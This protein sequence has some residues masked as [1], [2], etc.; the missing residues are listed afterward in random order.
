MTS[1]LQRPDRTTRSVRTKFFKLTE[2]Q[3]I[4]RLLQPMGEIKMVYTHWLNR[5]SI[6]CLGD[7]C[8]ICS[9]NQEIL[10]RV[11]KEVGQKEAWKQAKK[12]EGFNPWQ[13]RYYANVLDRTPVKV[14]PEAA[15]GT[16]NKINAAGEFP[17]LCEET[18][19]PL[20]D[21][22]VTSS[23]TVRVLSS[24]KTLF[25]DLDAIDLATCGLESDESG[26]PIPLGI[27]NYDVALIVSGEGRERNVSPVPQ[28]S[29]NDVVEVTEELYDLNK[30]IITLTSDEVSSFIRGVS[31]RDIFTSRNAIENIE[32]KKEAIA[33]DIETVSNLEDEIT[34]SVKALL[35]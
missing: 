1:R 17:V 5:I 31:L 30:A 22:P 9:N 33:Q 11:S 18:K 12:E 3:H 28:A 19:L 23:N 4:I 29:R 8:P 7:T 15:K 27:T 10:T 16:E 35:D 26:M 2:G 21:V 6:E 25:E 34:D 13:L 14:H 32:I 24:G 20:A